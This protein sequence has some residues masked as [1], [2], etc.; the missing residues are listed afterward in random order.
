MNE[1]TESAAA[2]SSSELVG[3]LCR[4]DGTRRI[5]ELGDWDVCPLEGG[6][7]TSLSSNPCCTCGKISGFPSATLKIELRKETPATIAK[8]REIIMQPNDKSSNVPPKT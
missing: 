1:K 3:L 6:G 4:C 7:H 8:L 5:E 2:V